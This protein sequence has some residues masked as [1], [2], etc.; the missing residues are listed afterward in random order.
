MDTCFIYYALINDLERLLAFCVGSVF[1]SLSKSDFENFEIAWPDRTTRK[2]IAA[3]LGALDDKIEINRRMNQTLEAMA[4]AIFMSWFVDFDPVYSKADGCQP[5]G[6]D[7][8]TATVFPDIFEDS[9]L[10]PIPKGWLVAPLGEYVEVIKGLSYKGAG[11]ADEGV[12][13]HNLNSIYEGGSY[14]HEGIKFYTG[15]YRDRHV[16]RPG[17]VIVANTEQ[18]FDYLLIGF[19]AV[20]PRR[21]GSM[22]LFS[23]HL[24]CVRPL[25]NSPIISYFIYLLL[26][27][28]RFRDEV[29]GYTNGTTV[30]MLR[31]DGLK[32]PLFAFPPAEVIK[33]FQKIVT[34]LFEKAE[35]C[36]EESRTLAV[37]RD[38]LLPKLLSGEIRV[39]DSEKL[40]KGLV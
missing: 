18:G 1:P 20:I 34:P 9:P 13:L 30:N 29:T 37:T 32:R 15:E 27:D 23:H 7:S 11:L 39:T 28:Q 38:A 26:I 35:Q 12:P 25:T 10:G 22:G 8:E 31:E 3:I 24:F 16:V 6:I 36:L 19:P 2:A 17:D 21:F 4:R 14:K 33:R 40:L 5:S